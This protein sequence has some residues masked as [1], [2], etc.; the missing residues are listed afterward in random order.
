MSHWKVDFSWLSNKCVSS[1]FL[2][3][4]VHAIKQGDAVALREARFAAVFVSSSMLHLL[5]VWD[6]DPGPLCCGTPPGLSAP[7]CTDEWFE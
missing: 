2:M 7:L 4:S 5:L 6:G 3:N 1:L